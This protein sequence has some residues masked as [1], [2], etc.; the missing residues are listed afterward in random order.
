MVLGTTGANI[1]FLLFTNTIRDTLTRAIQTEI[2]GEGGGKALLSGSKNF[3]KLWKLT[4][5]MS[6]DPEAWKDKK[7]GEFGASYVRYI[8]SG[9]KGSSLVGADISSTRAS[10]AWAAGRARIL[11]KKTSA[12]A[13]NLRF[14]TMHP[15]EFMR[16]AMS[17]SEDMNRFAE[18]QASERAGMSRLEA[19]TNSADVTVDFK[20]MGIAG[21]VINEVVP[22]F[23]PSLQGTDK[24]MRTLF[25]GKEKRLSNLNKDA[26][27]LATKVATIPSAVFWVMNKDEDWY[28]ERPLW[29]KTLFW[30]VKAGDTVFKIPVPF[31]WGVTF[32]TLPIAAIDA[33]YNDSPDHLKQQIGIAVKSML[34]YDFPLEVQSV[35]PAWEAV[36]NM[37]RFTGIPIES[38]QMRRLV[39]EQ[40]FSPGTTGTAKAIGGVMSDI[41]LT[42]EFLRSPL[43]I[44][45]LTRGYLGS[46]TTELIKTAEAIGSGNFGEIAEGG[47]LKRVVANT[48]APGQSVPDF[49]KKLIAMD[50]A[51]QSAQN[52]L[53]AG[54]ADGAKRLLL[55]YGRKAGIPTDEIMQSLRTG[56]APKT[57][58]LFNKA[59]REMAEKRKEQDNAEL[60]RIAQEILGR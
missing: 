42:P 57:L 24:F 52:M 2:K 4:M 11:A 55:K 40:R 48:D 30:H 19:W 20:R 12:T 16:H 37:N 43:M 22:F 32:G 47:L 14:V 56:K 17:F 33:W 5:E 44:D 46:V 8:S 54:D 35:K 50:Q 45:H 18:W 23:N 58:R 31:E 59:A 49:Y 3:G 27:L 39:P 38:N 7:W 21:R 28:K 26:L 13:E 10:N 6:K 53:E 29:E 51:W 25:S 15:I 34:P 60:T 36:A 1:G 41:P 9:V